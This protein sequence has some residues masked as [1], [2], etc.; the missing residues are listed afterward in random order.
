LVRHT[1]YE[2]PDS[3]KVCKLNSGAP[4]A[5]KKTNEIFV[6]GFDGFE[7]QYSIAHEYLHLAFKYHPIGNSERDI[8]RIAKK[9]VTMF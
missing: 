5:N 9:L 7:N 6:R 2:R 1:G 4:F 8:D 3:F